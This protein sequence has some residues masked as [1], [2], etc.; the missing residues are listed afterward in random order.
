VTEIWSVY[1][2]TGEYSDWT[3][4]E[5]RAFGSETEANEFAGACNDWVKERGM[6]ADDPTSDYYE[7][8]EAKHPLDPNFSCDYTGTEYSVHKIPFGL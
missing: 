5:V 8:D 7:R 3:M 1:G 4:W 6:H 2:T